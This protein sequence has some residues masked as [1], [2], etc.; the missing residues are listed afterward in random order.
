[1]MDT[2]V[3]NTHNNGT[4]GRGFKAD[5]KPW[6]IELQHQQEAMH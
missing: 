1:M 4:H 2:R 3:N 6:V 5:R